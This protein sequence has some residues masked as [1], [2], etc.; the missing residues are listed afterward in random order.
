MPQ[1]QSLMVPG[2]GMPTNTLHYEPEIA[3][4]LLD[5]KIVALPLENALKSDARSFRPPP[6]ATPRSFGHSI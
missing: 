6:L 5:P 1:V 4:L 3:Q 2:Q